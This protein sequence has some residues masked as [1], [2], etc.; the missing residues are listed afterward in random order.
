MSCG[1]ARNH[2]TLPAPHAD[3]TVKAGGQDCTRHL[4]RRHRDP[5]RTRSSRDHLYTGGF[6]CRAGSRS[7]ADERIIP[8]AIAIRNPKSEIALVPD[9]YFLQDVA[10]ACVANIIARLDISA[11]SSRFS[12]FIPLPTR[13]MPA[14]EKWTMRTHPAGTWRR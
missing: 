5:S 8:H 12:A 13:P 10:Q 9:T 7:I 11:I 2:S 14:T 6:L 1:P 3:E 4:V